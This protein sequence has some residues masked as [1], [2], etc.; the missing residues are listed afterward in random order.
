[1]LGAGAGDAATSPLP[2]ER[3]LRLGGL[4]SIIYFG[5]CGGAF[6]IESP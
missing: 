3:R 1:V 4:V 5:G 2:R 6:G